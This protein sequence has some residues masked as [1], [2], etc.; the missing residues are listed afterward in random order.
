MKLT[1][2]SNYNQ[3]VK[4]RLSMLKVGESF[5]VD[6]IENEARIKN[7]VRRAIQCHNEETG[8]EK[9]FNVRA[10]YIKCQILITRDK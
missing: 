10:L 8:L 7:A 4:S 9:Q 3:T 6:F 2:E 5:T 1:E